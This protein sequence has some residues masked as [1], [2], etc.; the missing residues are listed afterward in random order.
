MSPKAWDAAEVLS[1][2]VI[3]NLSDFSPWESV[4][5]KEITVQIQINTDENIQGS[6]ALIAQFSDQIRDNLDRYSQHITRIEVHLSDN[7]AGKSGN[8]D[9][10]CLM[11]VRLEGQQPKVV[12]NKAGVL[13]SAFTGAIHKLL[14]VLESDLGKITHQKGAD[15]IRTG[16]L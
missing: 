9:K 15:T 8:S 7:N 11:E 3:T 5:K 10:R 1:L 6:E 12:S 2:E 16:S 4:G 13:E 14:R